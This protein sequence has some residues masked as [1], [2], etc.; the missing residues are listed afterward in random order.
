MQ[1]SPAPSAP[2]GTHASRGARVVLLLAVLA[3]AALVR[4]SSWPHVHTAHGW[5]FDDGDSYY[6]LLR[7]EQTVRARGR[8][9][10]FDPRLSFPDGERIQWHVGYDLPMAALVAVR[11]GGAPARACLEETAAWSTPALGVATTLLVYALAQLLVGPWCALLATFLFAAYPFAAGG[12]LLGHVDHHV[13]EPTCVAAWFLL[14]ARRWHIA[15]GVAAGLSLAVFPTALLPIAATLGALGFDRLWRLRRDGRRDTAL[16]R[17]ALA[18]AVTAVPVALTGAFPDRFEAA[19]TSPFQV[20]LLGGAALAC[21]LIEW[22]AAR[23]EQTPRARVGRALAIALGLFAALAWT[24][25]AALAPLVVFSR[26]AGSWTGVVQQQPLA[27]GVL[28]SAIL[29]VIALVACALTV[30]RGS[31]ANTPALRALGL[32]GFPLSLAGF[33]QMRFLMAASPL[34]AIALAVAWSDTHDWL[35][36]RT[37]DEAPRVRLVSGLVSASF[38]LLLLA[39]L[40]E[41]ASGAPAP[42]RFE[43]GIRVLERLDTRDHAAARTSILS[44]WKWGHHILYFT[45][46]AAVANPFML[47]GADRANAEARNAL[48]A[49]TPE[50]LDAVM[51]AR[52]S[53]Y[54][55]VEA[56]FDAVSL[57]QSLGRRVPRDPAAMALLA[58]EITGWSSL[59]LADAEGGVR[60]YERVPGARIVGDATPGSRVEATLMLRPIASGFVSRRFATTASPT[61]RFELR[62]PEW[63]RSAN[64]VRSP[65]AYAIGN[66]GASVTEAD[67]R[68][69]NIVPAKCR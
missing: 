14:L 44:D 60:L 49:E 31:A 12:A 47:S 37:R 28:A 10:M 46:F 33:A 50:R 36:R 45:R 5:R 22:L 65:V 23:P 63:T 58:S 19:S 48:L 53:R 40:R 42:R 39:P 34:I 61:G 43:D 62:V 68:A 21:L 30:A 20:T 7:I 57:A 56:P 9:P 67:V 59:R 3:L 18:A 4:V 13:L 41:Y 69:E 17:F 1:P 29:V 11:C 15:A 54:L 16:A 38:A 55:L 25:R 52:R 6:H 2:S 66:C 32:A 51:R 24:L 35:R 64:L 26:A 27:H 8:V